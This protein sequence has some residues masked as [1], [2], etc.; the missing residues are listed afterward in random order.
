[1]KTKLGLFVVLSFSLLFSFTAFAQIAPKLP[2][3]YVHWTAAED[4]NGAFALV[5]VRVN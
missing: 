1:M 4:A 5:L 3:K 2:E